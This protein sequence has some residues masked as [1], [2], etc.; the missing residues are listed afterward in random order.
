MRL[1]TKCSAE[2]QHEEQSDAQEQNPGVESD[3]SIKH[4]INAQPGIQT[5]FVY[6]LLLYHFLL[7]SMRCA[8]ERSLLTA[9]LRVGPM[10]VKK[11]ER[12]KLRTMFREASYMHADR[13]GGVGQVIEATPLSIPFFRF[14]YICTRIKTGYR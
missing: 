13:P 4:F 14:R 12:D 2:G 8:N 9:V 5:F 1:K 7:S 11:K 6:R 10:M 3:D